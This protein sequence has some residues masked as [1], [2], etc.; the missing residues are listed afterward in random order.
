MHTVK[1][2]GIVNEAEV[3]VEHIKYLE[4]IKAVKHLP[5]IYPFI[6]F[7]NTFILM[8]L[9]FWVFYCFI[10]ISL[11][12]IITFQYKE[13][14]NHILIFITYFVHLVCFLFLD[15]PSGVNLNIA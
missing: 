8:F 5:S 12:S 9:V 3:D 2:F 1:G 4:Y 6:S 14:W 11:D 15:F 13:C 7:T 10:L